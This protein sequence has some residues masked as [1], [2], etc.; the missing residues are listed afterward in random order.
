MK[1]IAIVD[2][3]ETLFGFND[4]LRECA[5]SHG[6]PFPT[7]K[8][9]THWNAI[10][11]FIPKD[12]VIKLFDHIH[13]HQCD[14]PPFPDAKDFLKFMKKHFFVI[15][16]SH[17]HPDHAPMLIE[18]LK[19]HDLIYNTVNVSF[20]KTRLFVSPSVK[21]VVDDR[22]E[23]LRIAMDKGIVAVGLRRPWNQNSKD[24]DYLLFE[25]LPEI[26]E[27]IEKNVIGGTKCLNY[28]GTSVH[29]STTLMNVE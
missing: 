17:R 19:V 3:D 7:M 29:G 9:C 24:R 4:A 20:D 12:E 6:Y 2:V 26:Q 13:E 1:S 14:Y 22:D 8:E 16:A 23:T 10:Y 21:V 18:W 11:D 28:T 15:I 5:L 27:Y 25:S